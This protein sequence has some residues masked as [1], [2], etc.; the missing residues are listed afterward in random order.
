M[1]ISWT[2]WFVSKNYRIYLLTLQIISSALVYCCKIVVFFLRN[3]IELRI[4]QQ[5]IYVIKPQ[6]SYNEKR[7]RGKVEIRYLKEGN[8][9]LME[10]VSSR[11]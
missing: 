2:Q 1:V 9:F 8:S 6:L 11:V 4:T 10:T 5:F 3:K 7:K